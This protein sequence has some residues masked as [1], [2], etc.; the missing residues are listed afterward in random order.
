MDHLNNNMTVL[1]VSYYFPP[2]AAVGGK[3]IARFCKYLP[4]FG[5]KPIVLTVDESCCELLDSSYP[6]PDGVTVHRVHP[7]KVPLDFYREWK[8]RRE[9]VRTAEP[10]AP[11][12]EP[13]RTQRGSWL[14][15][16]LLAALTIPDQ[17]WGWKKPALIESDAIFKRAKIDAVFSSGPPWTTHR[18]AQEISRIYSVPWIADFR[19]AWVSDQWR[20]EQLPGWRNSLDWRLEESC[21][22]QATSVVCTTEQ[23]RQSLSKAHPGI[24][25]EKLTVITNGFDGELPGPNVE[26]I[27]RNAA[28][29]LLHAGQLY[30]GRRIDSFCRAI[31]SLI[32]SGKLKQGGLQAQF[33]GDVDQEILEGARAAAPDL[34][35]DGTV[36]MLPPVGWKEVQERLRRADILLIV[37]GDHPTAIPAKFFE[38]LQTGKPILGIAQEGALR[39]AIQQT[40]CG[41]VADPRRPDEM[42]TAILRVLEMKPQSAAQIRN[43]AGRYHF[44]ELT[45]QLAS[46]IREAV[47]TSFTAKRR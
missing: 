21:L 26:S 1:V 31:G 2:D 11:A 16:N 32:R 4:Q 34:F 47:A 44:R 37:Q 24:L 40:G 38:Y 15:N 14:R 20:D 3:R 35:E 12:T 17:Y 45:T 19:D 41:L 28:P 18:V 25:A 9:T 23:L 29:V 30:S 10:N 33:L 27:A 6:T 39:E 46:H 13:P 5:I 8:A 22:K 7:G 36:S 43:M 42:E